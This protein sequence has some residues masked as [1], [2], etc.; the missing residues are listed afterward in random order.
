MEFTVRGE[1]T[2]AYT[3][4]RSL[5]VSMPSIVFVHGAGLD[6]TVWIQQSRWFAHHGYNVLALDL[7]GH[8]RSSGP[9]LT[10]I[11]DMAGWLH[12]C[13]D[14][15]ELERPAV[16]GHSMGALVTLQAAGTKPDRFAWA[17]LLGIAVPMQVSDELLDAARKQPADAH[18]MITGWGHGFSAQLGRNPAPGMW[19]TGSAIRLLQ[20]GAAGALANDLT[21]C[22][23]YTAGMDAAA[24]TTCPTLV[25]LGSEDVMASPR[26]AGA[27]VEALPDVTRVDLAQCG[28]MMMAE[29]PDQVREAMA[30][31]VNSALE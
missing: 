5:D 14:A 7:P 28:H 6:H 29:K 13:V 16:A 15:L 31:S 23:A 4:A 30:S 1:S 26:A 18:R 3:G 27:V 12:E 8:G 9:L 24:S 11:E 20:R 2:Y 10:S 19:M 17:G 21:A 22:N 25:L